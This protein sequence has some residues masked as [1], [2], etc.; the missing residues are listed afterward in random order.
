MQKAFYYRITTLLLG[1]LF[2][3]FSC[4]CKKEDIPDGPK[5][6]KIMTFNVLYNTSFQSSVDVIKEVEADIIGLQEASYNR[7]YTIVTKLNYYYHQFSKTPANR[8]GEDTGILSKFPIIEAYD[9]GVLIEIKTGLKVAVFSVHL[10]PY[11]YEPY[12]FRD[13][14]IE[15]PEEAINSSTAN[16][17]PGILT[18]LSKI[19]LLLNEEIPVFLTGDFNEPSH[20]DWTTEAASHHFGKVVSWPVSSR[21]E[22]TGLTDAY[23]SYYPDEIA[24]PGITWTTFETANEVYDRIDYIYHDTNNAFNL[25]KIE[26]VGGTGD[27][28]EII[29]NDYASDHYAVVA[30]YEIE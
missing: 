14:I 1:V 23:R 9:D 16:R 18:V 28:A 3:G 19:D 24:H 29:I 6:V 30:T 11:P 10:L 8:S 22:E 17:L 25:K 5:E 4:A 21:I 13:G 2:I 15:T 7:V 12:D 27:T 26:L 20:Q